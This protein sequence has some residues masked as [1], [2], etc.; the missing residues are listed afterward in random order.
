MKLLD[1]I[2]YTY[3]WAY[4]SKGGGLYNKLYKDPVGISIVIAML[5]SIGTFPLLLVLSRWIGLTFNHKIVYFSYI[6]LM[7]GISLAY[8]YWGK[9]YKK[10]ALNEEYKSRVYRIAAILYPIICIVA[11]FVAFMIMCSENIAKYGAN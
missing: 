8:F 1:G 7:T 6:L 4:H 11:M 2:F 5:F 3:Y 9:R 10:I